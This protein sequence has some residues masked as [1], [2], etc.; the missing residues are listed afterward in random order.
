MKLKYKRVS[1][2]LSGEAMGS[3]RDTVDFDAVERIAGEIQTLN[4]AGVQVGVTI[5]GGNI[6]RGRSAGEMDRNKADQ[7]GMLA[8]AINSLAMEAALKQRG[9]P[10]RV[11]SSLPMERV[12]DT[13]TAQRAEE[14]F[15]AGQVV[16]FACGSG[17]PFFPRIRRQRLKRPRR[18]RM[19][20]CWPKMWMRF[21]LRIQMLLR[22]RSAI[23]T[24][25]MMR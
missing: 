12:C 8:T 17:L 11:L 1:L 3:G 2:K 22:V 19:C 14:A 5:G 13:F 4:D 20:C 6:W 7:M 21:I 16:L 9:V 25:P 15:A 23:P 10:C 24:L 18:M